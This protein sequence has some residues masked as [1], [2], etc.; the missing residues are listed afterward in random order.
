M[1]TITNTNPSQKE[2]QYKPLKDRV[3]EPIRQVTW[4][5]ADAYCRWAGKRLPTEAE[6][7]YA[8]GGVE[9]RAY[10]WGDS[11]AN[12]RSCKSLLARLLPRKCPMWALIHKARHQRVY[13]T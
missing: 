6:H 13:W 3:D 12:V 5:A 11:G 10:A 1:P 2:M 8:A 9:K 4:Y 7:E